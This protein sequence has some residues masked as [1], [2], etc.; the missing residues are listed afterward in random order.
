[1]CSDGSN[2]MNTI[3]IDDM[4]LQNG[5]KLKGQSEKKIRFKLP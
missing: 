4:V 2:V 5:D 3:V 1:M